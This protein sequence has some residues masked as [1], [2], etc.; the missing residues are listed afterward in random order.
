MENIIYTP[1]GTIHSPFECVD[2]TPIQS[3]GAKGVKGTIT[4]QE[5]FAQGLKDLSDFSHIII[6]YH[7]HLSSGCAMLVK[8]FLDDHERGVFSTRAPRRPNPI[9]ISVVRLTNVDGNTLF[10]E[11]VDV[12]NN[13]PLLDIKPYVPDFDCKDVEKIGWLTKR[14]RGVT[15]ARA[16]RRF[17]E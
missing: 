9:G 14:S 7:F 13:T 6:L 16:D 15:T 12:I 8:P 4:I 2:G 5:R 11:D 3:T 17:E 1:I 10:I